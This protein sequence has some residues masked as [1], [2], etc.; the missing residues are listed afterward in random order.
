M[1]QSD[2]GGLVDRIPALKSDD[3]GSNPLR[4]N[5]LRKKKFKCDFYTMCEK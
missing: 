4:A 3:P 1:W 2:I 5:F